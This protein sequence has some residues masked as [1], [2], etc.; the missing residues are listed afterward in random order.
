MLRITCVL[1]AAAATAAS[2]QGPGTVAE[3]HDFVELLQHKVTRHKVV[4]ASRHHAGA[5]HA[6]GR[7]DEIITIFPGAAP[8]EHLRHIAGGREVSGPPDPTNDVAAR[9]CP[10]D[11][12]GTWFYNVT[13]PQLYAFYADP[14]SPNFKDAAVLVFPGGGFDFLAWNKEGTD[15]AAWLQSMGISAFVLKYRVPEGQAVSL[16]DAQRAVSLVRSRASELSIN[17]SRIGVIGFSA[18]GGL[19]GSITGTPSRQYAPIDEIDEFGFEPDFAL[20]IYGS[21]SPQHALRAPP[22]FLASTT[23][24]P[25]VPQQS[26]T[27]FFEALQAAGRKGE[28]HVYEDGGHGYGRCTMYTMTGRA[29]TVCQWTV[30]AARWIDAVVF[31]TYPPLPQND[32]GA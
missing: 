29:D 10:G 5:V 7:E 14:S 3:I 19:V 9:C 13:V 31:G 32:Y 18:G 15:I 17:A 11:T 8:R 1:L 28:L 22:S 4:K 6:T 25:C 30:D 23:D 16:V 2:A 24:D 27:L 26:V 12:A 20:Y 21:G